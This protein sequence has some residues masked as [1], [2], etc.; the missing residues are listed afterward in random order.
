MRIE[1]ILTRGLEHPYQDI[2]FVERR[3]SIGFATDNDPE[4][5]SDATTDLMV[6]P[7][8]WS[9]TASLVLAR[10]YFLKSALP[11]RRKQIEEA[12]MPQW[13]WRSVEEEDNPSGR[14]TSNRGE[15]DCR[16]IFH[17]LAGCWTYW[18]VRGN[19]FNSD[20]DARIYYDE[21][22]RALVL[23]KFAPNSPQ[24]FNTGRHWAYGIGSETSFVHS[25]FIQSVADTL[26]DDGGILD[27]ITNEARIASYGSGT[28]ANFSAIRGSN[29]K[30]TLGGH[31]S[32]LMAVLKSSDRAAHLITST[33]ST[34]Q[35]SK[36][37]IVDIDHPQIEEF[38]DWKVKEE[39]KVAALAAGSSRCAPALVSLFHAARQLHLSSDTKSDHRKL[40][41]LAIGQAETVGAAPSHINATIL[42]ARET[43]T[44]PNFDEFDLNWD[45]EGYHGVSG[46]NSNNSIRVSNDFLHAVIGK[47]TWPLKN[48]TDGQTAQSLAANELWQKAVLAAWSCADP[49]MHFSDTIND[50][51][52]CSSSG[53]I[54]GSN[55]CSEFMFLDQTAT[56]LA[57]VNLAGFGGN[58]DNFDIAEFEHVV[59]LV[60]L[61]LEI[62]VSM[63]DYPS[64]DICTQTTR[65]RPLGIGF[66]NLGGL[67]MR[68]AIAYDSDEA[69][70]SCAALSALMSGKAY[71]VS[72]EIARKLS[73]FAE[74]TKNRAAMLK[75]I[76]NHHLLAQGQPQRCQGLSMPPGAVNFQPCPRQDLVIHAKASWEE[77]LRMGKKHGFRNAQISAIAPTGTISLIMDCDTMGIEPDYSLVKFKQLSGGGLLKIINRTIPHALKELGYDLEEIDAIEAYLLGQLDLDAAP[78]INSQTLIQRGFSRAMIASVKRALPTAKSIQELLSPPRIGL[79]FCQR[80]F[81]ID[82]DVLGQADFDFLAWL[83]FSLDQIEQANFA[84]FGHG[85]LEGAPHIHPRHLSIFH[86]AL[87]QGR[88]TE[89]A[90]S[91]QAHLGMMAAAQ[92]FVSGAISKTVNLPHTATLAQCEEVFL[93]AWKCGLK[94]IA[95]YRDGSKL[96]QPLSSADGPEGMIEYLESADNLEKTS[97]NTARRIGI[98]G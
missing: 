21:M 27:L 74:F 29:E 66:A 52:T 92:P 77:A 33:G 20:T 4:K 84:C 61:C 85:T 6:F 95:I 5:N 63:A 91:V 50:W 55:S 43:A 23:Q 90:I 67:L 18:G 70:A 65:Y 75:V 82:E 31:A 83:G 1:N 68:S 16:Q 45:A 60:T 42:V 58:L 97:R 78:H 14:S 24:W 30:L 10:K 22:I 13:L 56:T 3:V 88:N 37:V 17:R 51:H 9:E 72:A 54:N 8:H 41:K 93:S 96:S 7:G 98:G 34:R 80:A 57:S 89:S 81:G 38:I 94:A 53:P 11:R 26:T 25:C 49:G 2:T 12:G 35:P 71:A 86:C 69:R 19:Y 40:L 76:H 32:G 79:S 28:G 48:R 62:S 36:M 39:H 46:Q 64:Q 15:T 87:A 47:K 44:P 59:R 73:P